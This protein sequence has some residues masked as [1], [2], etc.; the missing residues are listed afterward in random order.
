MT[1]SQSL[2]DFF[3]RM[4]NKHASKQHGLVGNKRPVK[5]ASKKANKAA[6]RARQITLQNSIRESLA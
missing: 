1:I 3:K 4:T 5:T 2:F 6:N